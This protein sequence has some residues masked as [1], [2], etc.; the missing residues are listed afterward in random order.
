M[1]VIIGLCILVAII[2]AAC[3]W[4][5]IGY[6]FMSVYDFGMWK[7]M[8]YDNYRSWSMMNGVN[9]VSDISYKFHPNFIRATFDNMHELGDLVVSA[10]CGVFFPIIIIFHF[11]FLMIGT[12]YNRLDGRLSNIEGLTVTRDRPNENKKIPDAWED[13]EESNR[14]NYAMEGNP[15]W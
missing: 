4:F 11:L 5:G 8:K 15:D 6:F 13:F 12:A 7:R 3:V 9:D 10:I 1:N 2:L 14:N